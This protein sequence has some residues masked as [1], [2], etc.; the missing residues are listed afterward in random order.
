MIFLSVG[1]KD[2]PVQNAADAINLPDIKE[3]LKKKEEEERARIE[4]EKLKDK[5]R[6]KRSDKE[7]F[8][9]VSWDIDVDVF[10]LW[11]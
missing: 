10:F 5:R 6:I 1:V 8:A 11:K 4:E 3:Q 7:A 9:R 2:E